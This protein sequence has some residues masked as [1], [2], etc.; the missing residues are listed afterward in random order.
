MKEF[1][2]LFSMLL[3]DLNNKNVY[4]NDYIRIIR[5]KNIDSEVLSNF[6]VPVLLPIDYRY[7]NEI[8]PIDEQNEY[9]LIKVKDLFE[10]SLNIIN[11][12]K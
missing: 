2:I 12:L 1:I 3:N 7:D 11:L 6:G 4:S 8:I 5:A 9:E 10:E